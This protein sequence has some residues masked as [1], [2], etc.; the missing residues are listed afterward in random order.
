VKTGFVHVAGVLLG[1]GVA[2][3]AA[4]PQP[5]RARLVADASAP[6]PDGTLQ[7]G[8][9]LEI[10]E[11]WHIY[12]KNPGDAGLATE[13]RLTLPEGLEAAAPR[14]PA[15]HRFTQPGGLVGYGYERSLLLASEVRLAGPTP[16]P[17]APVA[18]EASWLAC[19]DVCLIGS[20]RLEGRW[21]LDVAAAEFERWRAELPA[22]GPPFSVNVTGGLAP[23]ARRADLVV[24]LS[25]PAPPG[26][27]ELFPE[28]GGRLKVASPRVQTR[29]SLT[30][31]DLE[32]A[33]VGSGGAPADHLAAV[34]AASDAAGRRR[35]WE[36]AIPLAGQ[37]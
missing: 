2:V 14:W 23:G 1:L 34:V 35:A 26:E 33:K 12:W 24:W 21:P 15:P 31:V 19:K 9:L 37:P 18:A 27:V 36:I 30:R 17:G 13:A 3:G 11:G 6:A 10:D 20:A 25:W 4:E 32:V 16:A 22:A 8:V 7:V 29:G 5:V 28:A